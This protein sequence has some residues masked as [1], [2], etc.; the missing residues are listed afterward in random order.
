M[1]SDAII[2]GL[3]G[4]VGS[5]KSS[6]C[7][8]EL[9]QRGIRQ[10]PGPDGVRRSK[11]GVLRGT[12]KQLEDTTE[13]TFLQWAPPHQFGVWTPSRHHYMIKA[14]R[15]PGDDRGAEIEI[16]FRALERQDQIS[17]L[18]SLELTGAWVNEARDIPWPIVDALRA[19]TGRF[20]PMRDG[21]A[22]WHGVILD[23]NPPD[24]DSDW[25]KFF[26][27]MDHTESV[28]KLAM[29][30]EYAGMT[31]DGFRQIFKQPSGLSP[32]AENI[33]N[34]RPGYYQSES[35]GKSREW[36]KIYVE[37][38][39]GFVADGMAVW[40][41]YNDSVHCP[42]DPKDRP[43][44][45]NTRPILRSW[46]SSGLTPACVLSQMTSRNQWIVFDEII[47]EGLGA[48]RFSDQVLDHCAREWRG[49][50]FDD[51]GDPAGSSRSPSDERRYFEILLAKGILIEPAIQ[52]LAIRL[53]SVRRPLNSLVEGRPQFVLHPRCKTL[54]R[55][56]LGGYHFRRMKIH[57]ER[58][59]REP[60][61]NGFSHVADALGYG[62]TRFFGS[63]LLSRREDFRY[64][65]DDNPFARGAGRRA[66]TGY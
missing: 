57:G 53:E 15:A 58:Y 43:R 62:G 42:D 52:T 44:P 8:I 27:T 65:E 19:R 59:T 18:L 6:A 66:T 49:F 46:D 22:T 5:G 33:P 40:P 31:V 13:Q 38:Q 2:R 29:V 9:L 32:Q 30:P 14:L 61:K 20:P 47:A 23:T 63:G 21:G 10:K 28:A 34:L 11:W 24:V 51:I 50:E 39:Y 35:I 41:E 1:D 64:R 17:D 16:I 45:S 54:R 55:A 26:E 48:D 56:M 12:V 60:E 36:I 25:F 7:V 37:G 4:P 3:M